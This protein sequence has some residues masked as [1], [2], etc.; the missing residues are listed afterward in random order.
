VPSR[1]AFCAQKIADRISNGRRDLGRQRL[2]GELRR[3][4]VRLEEDHAVLTLNQ[5]L[6]ESSLLVLRQGAINVVETEIDELL[7]VDHGKNSV[8]FSFSMGGGR[9]GFPI[10]LNFFGD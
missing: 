10:Y 1:A 4:S 3:T 8:M 2:S 9:L 7:T 6:G 5:V